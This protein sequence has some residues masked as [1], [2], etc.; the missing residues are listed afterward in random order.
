LSLDQTPQKPVIREVKPAVDALAAARWE[1]V[2]DKITVNIGDF[3]NIDRVNPSYFTRSN[4]VAVIIGVENY[5]YMSP[6]LYAENDAKYIEEYCTTVLGI[7][8]SKVHK[9]TS[10]KVIGNFY[11]N[12]FNPIYG[13]LQN[14]IDSGKTDL[15]VF[16]SGH[17]IPSQDGEKVYFL[18][19][20]GQVAGIEDSG[21]ELEKF[22]TFLAGL[23]AKTQSCSW[24]PVLRVFPGQVKITGRIIW[25]I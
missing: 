1:K 4:A 15:F 9:Y 7:P 13:K 5:Q 21:F 17:G 20:D 6:A 12:I 3:D 8:L 25:R 10:E 19:A 22:Y 23:H 24:M 2:P 18:P 16:Y 14:W 11:N